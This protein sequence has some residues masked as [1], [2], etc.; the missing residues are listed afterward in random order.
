VLLSSGVFHSPQILLASGI[1]YSVHDSIPLVKSL[2]G[3]GQNLSDHV[4]LGIVFEASTSLRDCSQKVRP[5]KIP[6]VLY[7]YLRHGTDPLT[8]QMVETATFVRLE[9]IAPD[10]V[11]KE[12]AA[13]L[14][15]SVEWPGAPHIELL[16]L[17]SYYDGNEVPTI[18]NVKLQLLFDR[19]CPS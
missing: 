8:S 9:D 11:A 1:G 13:A 3:V 5:A 7:D 10:F 16:F 12:K 17:V 14:A 4:G 6:R 2:P 18:P 19:T 15:G